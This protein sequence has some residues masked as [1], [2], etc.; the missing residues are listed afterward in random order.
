M[1][2]CRLP[3][4]LS[5]LPH[6]VDPEGAPSNGEPRLGSNGFSSFL[7]FVFGGCNR[8][9][10]RSRNVDHARDCAHRYLWSLFVSQL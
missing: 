6:A 10:R 3:I 4:F 2:S 7:L 9:E 8:G 5:K 1:K